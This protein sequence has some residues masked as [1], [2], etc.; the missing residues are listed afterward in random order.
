MPVYGELKALAL[1]NRSV[2]VALSPES[3]AILFNAI[4]EGTARIWLWSGSGD[5]GSLTPTEYRDV[6]QMLSLA[7][8]ELMSNLLVGT[9]FPHVCASIP[10]GALACDGASYQRVDY[11]A[12]Y[13]ALDAAFITDADNFVVPDLSGRFPLGVSAGHVIA[14]TGGS[15]THT[16]TNSEMPVHSHTYGKPE[17]PTLVFAPGEVPVAT[18][19]IFPDVTGNTGG[20]Q[21]H[22]NMPPFM[23]VRWAIWAA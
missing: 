23:A 9:I 19:D 14:S 22:N 11:P 3:S 7:E 17:I 1:N 21:A 5:G 16:L 4:G 20:G 8:R 18:L 6:L 2:V 12:L 10:A 15:E 13:A